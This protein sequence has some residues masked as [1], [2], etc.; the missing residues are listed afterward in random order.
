MKTKETKKNPSIV[1]LNEMEKE[2]PP[3]ASKRPEFFFCF[4]E[5][6]EKK[7]NTPRGQKRGETETF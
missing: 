5:S 1:H 4:L 6:G 2:S 3:P 7:T